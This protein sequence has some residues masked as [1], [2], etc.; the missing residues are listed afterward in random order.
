MTKVKGL[1]DREGRIYSVEVLAIAGERWE[2]K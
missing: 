2:R 1:N